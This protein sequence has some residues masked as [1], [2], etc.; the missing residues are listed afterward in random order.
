M[1]RNTPEWLSPSLLMILTLW[2]ELAALAKL[3]Q[4]RVSH[5]PSLIDV[6]PTMKHRIARHRGQTFSSL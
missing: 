1:G 6:F 4:T 3:Q 2:S 5:G